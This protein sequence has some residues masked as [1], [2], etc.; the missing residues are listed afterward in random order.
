MNILNLFAGIG[1][2]RTLWGD[3]H[4]ITAV[5]Y[6]AEIAAIYQAR[7]PEDTVVVG[8]AYAYLESHF[9]E[10]DFI[11]ASPPCQSHTILLPSNMAQGAKMQLP[12][13]KLY[14]MVIALS[15]FYS[16]LFA[17]E[18]VNPYYIPL[19][20]PTSKIG[21]HPI[22]SNYNIPEKKFKKKQFKG[23]GGTKNESL[24]TLCMFLQID[25]KTVEGIPNI[26]Q[27][28]RNGVDP[29]AGKYILDC[30]IKPKQHTLF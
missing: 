29:N 27:Y 26:K 30:A 15:K 18:N 1:G 25:P 5:E 20:K 3:K 23:D 9:R 6:D 8:D 19:M 12:D 17:I 10:F 24:E 4:Q 22:W 16:G 13:L 14:S 2:N 7:F 11:W 28:L 21:R